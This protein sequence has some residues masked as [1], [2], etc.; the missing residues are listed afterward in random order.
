M[1]VPE[2]F[3]YLS[4]HAHNIMANMETRPRTVLNHHT[5]KRQ[6]FLKRQK[7]LSKGSSRYFSM[8]GPVWGY[9]LERLGNE[10]ARMS[11][12]KVVGTVRTPF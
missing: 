10:V 3:G 4:Q 7:L 12:V 5:P 2:S 6:F 11:T 1:S 9:S 8:Y